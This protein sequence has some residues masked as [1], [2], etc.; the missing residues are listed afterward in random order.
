MGRHEVGF[1]EDTK[2]EDINEGRGCNFEASF[3]INKVP[4]NFHV[5]THSAEVQPAVIDMAHTIHELTFGD[6]LSETKIQGSFNALKYRSKLDGHSKSIVFVSKLNFYGWT[7]SL[8]E[9]F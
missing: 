8:I 7:V 2:K 5:S 9:F 6:D 4:G 1:V 3:Q